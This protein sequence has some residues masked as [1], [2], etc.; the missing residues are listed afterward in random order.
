MN[1]E[2]MQEIDRITIQ[3]IG[4]P[5]MVLM[6]RAALKVY[7]R[8]NRVIREKKRNGT[9]LAVCG[10]GNNGGDG[11]AVA[12]MLHVAGISVEICIVGESSKASEQLKQQ[13]EI[14][15]RL[16]VPFAEE[17]SYNDY[18]I[19]L[20]AIFG[21]G[22]S[23]P[24]HG[25]YE[26]VIEKINGSEAY[27]IAVDLPSGV[28]AD[29]GSILNVCV[30]ADETVTFGYQKVGLIRY[31]GAEMAGTVHVE[32]A[33]FPDQVYDLAMQRHPDWSQYRRMVKEDLALLPER[34]RHSNK[35]TFGKVLIVAGSKGM[36]GACYFS[37]KAALRTGAGLVKILTVEEN[38]S[39]LQA[40]LPE[41]VVLS[42]NEE[43]L[44]QEEYQRCYVNEIKQADLIVVGPG[45]G[46][47][48][49]AEQILRLVLNNTT[50][51]TIVDADGINLL[52]D[53]VTR[54]SKTVDITTDTE[55]DRI[56]QR[57]NWLAK[58]L[59]KKVIL[60]PHMKEFSR[61]IQCDISK[62]YNNFIDT[63]HL[64]S[65]NKVLICIIKGSV[66]SI[67]QGNRICFSNSGN[68]GLAT[69]GTG[70]VLTGVIGGLLAQGMDPY[71]A[72]CLG[73]YVHGLT[74]EC[75]STHYYSGSMIA[76]DVI[77]SLQ[78]VL[79]RKGELQE[80]IAES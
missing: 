44:A 31:P 53:W 28:N 14:A 6:E 56:Q 69:G 65:Y 71:E 21:I 52:A 5:S 45:L 64:C 77:E 23:R 60:T 79:A 12:R 33:G 48:P 34:P 57:M 74:S 11:V 42:Y 18:S 43:M 70:D 29:D 76:S 15:Q 2:L 54:K 30:Q 67:I 55:L 80:E 9:V 58:I 39:I 78:N 46:K 24:I 47:S 19:I 10:I 51:W 66:T 8:V 50:V 62:I 4:I 26:Q 75:Y 7:E 16:G 37:A 73:V 3:E 61:L 41:A 63:L 17:P 59:P 13:L 36:S 1:R 35:G 22:L 72:A 49:C 27:V 68:D 38:R 20:D 40:S 25:S 32:D